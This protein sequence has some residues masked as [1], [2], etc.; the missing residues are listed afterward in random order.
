MA[1]SPKT[2]KKVWRSNVFTVSVLLLTGW[3]GDTYPTL[4]GQFNDKP[5]TRVA[6]E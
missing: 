4:A 1:L 3:G 6:D 2:K 5:P